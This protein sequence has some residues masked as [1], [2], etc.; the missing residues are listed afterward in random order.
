MFKN[1]SDFLNYLIDIRNVT[2]IQA[3]LRNYDPPSVSLLFHMYLVCVFK[4]T[5]VYVDDI[6]CDCPFCHC[7]NVF[8]EFHTKCYLAV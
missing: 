7:T 1:I 5:H 2:K 4:C 3:Q 6:F 8:T